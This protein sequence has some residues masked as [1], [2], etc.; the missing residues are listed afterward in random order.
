MSW[1]FEWRR[2]RRRPRIAAGVKFC[3][4]V[5]PVG[6]SVA[7]RFD[8]TWAVGGVAALQPLRRGGQPPEAPTRPPPTSR[9][10]RRLLG[11]VAVD[12]RPAMSGR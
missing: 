5:G 1:P 8:V 9:A 12:R 2:R 7:R 4:A 6:R 3:W 11:R 10:G